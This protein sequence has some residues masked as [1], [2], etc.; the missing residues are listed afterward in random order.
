MWDYGLPFFLEHLFPCICHTHIF[1]PWNH[2]LPGKRSASFH[3]LL[4]Q[5]MLLISEVCVCTAHSAWPL[6][7]RADLSDLMWC[8]VIFHINKFCWHAVVSSIYLLISI[9]QHLAIIYCSWSCW[10]LMS[11]GLAGSGSVYKDKLLIFSGESCLEIP[12]DQ[13]K[14]LGL[15]TG[16]QKPMDREKRRVSWDSDPKWGGEPEALWCLMLLGDGAQVVL[17]LP[18]LPCWL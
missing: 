11:S 13:P 9:T 5:V 1:V 7:F 8:S 14:G 12:G 15:T 10:S 4:S 17:Q 18:S 2:I 16:S 3:T 6:P